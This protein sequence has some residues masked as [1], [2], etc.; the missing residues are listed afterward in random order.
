MLRHPGT[1]QPAR[2]VLELCNGYKKDA[3]FYG[4]YATSRVDEDERFR[5]E[6][7]Q[8]GTKKAPGRLSSSENMWHTA[9][10]MQNQPTRSYPMYVA[11]DGYMFSY[12]DL[13]QAEARVVAYQ[14]RVEELIR[15]FEAVRDDRTLDVHRANAARIFQVPYEDIPTHDRDEDGTPTKRFLGK[16]CVHGLNY[17]MAP[18]RLAEECGIPISQAYE[19]YH[20]YH[21]A[22]PEIR[23]AW[24]EIVNEVRYKHMLFTPLGRRLIFMERLDEH[25]MDSVVAFVPQSTIGD[26]VASVI[27]NS[28]ED[29]DWPTSEARILLNIH[30]ALIA[31]HKRQHT[32]V[33]QNI[34]RKYAEE[35]IIIRGEPIIIPA[36][37]KQ[38]YPDENGVHRWSTIGES[39]EMGEA[40][41][42]E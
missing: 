13:S 25:S 7:K 20:A 32:D 9:Q 14:W 38:S 26:K 37:I 34:M 11:D 2:K 3:K 40:G 29:G 35:P 17:R 28:H 24:E 19:A 42:E 1:S 36:D 8:Y 41:A 22:F 18:Q 21:R 5:A 23:Q 6:W 27:Y 10:N 15:T 16:K 33:V 31:I 4:T 39:M 12:F 30:D